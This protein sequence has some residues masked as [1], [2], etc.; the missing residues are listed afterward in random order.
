[1][2]LDAERFAQARALFDELSA[3][4]A[5]ARG[6]IWRN[7]V[8]VDADVRAQVEAWLSAD[9][10]GDLSHGAA[11]LDALRSDWHRKHRA[12]HRVGPFELRT[13]LGEGGMGSVWLADRR[14]G[15][16]VQQVAIK[17]LAG[18][19]SVGSDLQRRFATEREILA[20]LNHPGIARMIDAG[21]TA[22]GEPYLVMEYVEGERID[23]WCAKHSTGFERRIQIVLDICDALQAAHSS[24]IVHRDLKPANILVDVQGRPHLL[25]F[26]IAK[27]IDASGLLHTVVETAADQRLMTIRYASPEQVRGERVGIASDLYSLGVVLYELLAGISP[28]DQATTTSLNLM[29]AI[30][31]QDPLPP[32]RIARHR[33]NAGE[34]DLARA[35]RGFGADLDAVVLKALRKSPSERYSTVVAFADDLRRLLDGRPVEARQGDGLYRA[36][37]LFRRHRVALTIALIGAMALATVALN[38]RWQRDEVAQERDK[39]VRTTRFLAD[40]FEQANPLNHRG[41][42][43]DAITMAERGTEALL[44][45]AALDRETRADLLRTAADVLLSLGRYPQALVATEAALRDAGE[46]QQ[47]QPN[48]RIGLQLLQADALAQNQ[49]TGEAVALLESLRTDPQLRDALVDG[50]ALRAEVLNLLARI[51]FER[52][53]VDA[54]TA[55]LNEGFA[56]WRLVFGQDDSAARMGDANGPGSELLASMLLTRCRIAVMR[57]GGADARSECAAAQNFRERHFAP[58]HPG[59]LNALNELAILA[60]NAS[61]DAEALRLSELILDRSRTVFGI[62]H[63]RTAVAAINLGVEYRAAGR[64]EDAIAQYRMAYET[65][66]ASR[67]EQHPHT[68]MALNNWAN[69][70]Y[71]TGDYETALRKHRDVQAKRRSSLPADDPD[72]AQSATNVAKSLWRLGRYAEAEAELAASPAPGDDGARRSRQL[73]LAE[74]R[75]ARDDAEGALLIARSVRS[76]IATAAPDVR[77]LAAACWIE[78]RALA[79]TGA[80]GDALKK[81]LLD[82][83]SALRRDEGRDF[84]DAAAVAAWRTAH[85]TPRSP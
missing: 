18:H 77:G 47:R 64:Y 33:L 12:G 21:Q 45:D 23:A 76:E 22:D 5:D 48:L 63:P 50:R 79:A 75:L 72:L 30:C 53:R 56:S 3:L 25:D 31:S 81:A 62:D 85:L 1:M 58:D 78:L 42:V 74:L 66:S 70:A 26:G 13:L 67:G 41:Q 60:G 84:V 73:V 8:S 61:D 20:S 83:D 54:S 14:D 35:R 49:R 29:Q 37:K 32:S 7:S 43:P 6:A 39:A 17:L 10:E 19:V 68:L 11:A 46:W 59:Q 16:V 24:L 28:Y 2:D 44:A 65:L 69:V 34:D 38:W 36:R 9:H 71:A 4:P 40:L 57:E 27:A 80:E 82:V 52:H 55:A 51:E 15:S